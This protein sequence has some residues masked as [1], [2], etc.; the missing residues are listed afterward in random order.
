MDIKKYRRYLSEI[1]ALYSISEIEAE[2]I[3]KAA[4]A[5]AYNAIGSAYIWKDG[6]ITL[7]KDDRGAVIYLKNYVVSQKQ[8]SRIISIFDEMLMDYAQKRDALNFALAVKNRLIDVEIIAETDVCFIVKPI[9]NFGSIEGYGFILPKNKLFH[10]EVLTLHD[11]TKVNCKGFNQNENAVLL[12][13]FDRQVALD[14]FHQHFNECLKSLNRVYLYKSISVQLN[15]HTKAI[16]FIL[17]WQTK[18]SSVVIS[19]LCKELRSVLGRCNIIFKELGY[20]KK[21]S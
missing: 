12:S 9:I 17:D 15:P 4:V 1:S 2:A 18:P 13:R 20:A 19:F 6:T 10:N 5:R 8:Y 16:T 21:R 7:A 11:Q 3:F 14:I